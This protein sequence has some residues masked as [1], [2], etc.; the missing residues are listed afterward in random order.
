MMCVLALCACASEHV[1]AQASVVDLQVVD[2]DGAGVMT[3]YL[4]DGQAFV[5]GSEG[6][7]YALRLR[8]RGGSRVLVVLTVDGVN[9]VSGQNGGWNQVGYVLDAGQTYEVNG[10]R[11]SN[12]QIAAFEFTGL[13]DSYAART[14]RPANVGVIGM[15]EFAEKPGPPKAW[16]APEA[17]IAGRPS[18]AEADLAK[19]AE[20]QQE[21]RSSNSAAVDASRAPEAARGPQPMDKL[22]TGHGEREWSTTRRVEFERATREPYSV[23][24]IQYDSFDAL[25]ASG[26][27]P[28]MRSRPRAFPGSE[29]YGFV[30]DPPSR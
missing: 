18:R 12:R 15:A 22:G 25:V 29:G 24:T 21:G 14:G 28:R 8:N 26:V 19:G 20:A 2:R 7:R 11:K 30:R 4:K 17:P 9:V 3:Q 10:W 6:R 5:A 23:T 16:I 13:R 1:S 27:I